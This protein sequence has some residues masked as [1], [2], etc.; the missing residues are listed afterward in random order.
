MATLSIMA[1]FA[2]RGEREATTV[3][4]VWL[5]DSRPTTLHVCKPNREFVGSVRQIDGDI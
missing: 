3:V 1:N 2:I 5:S 4:S